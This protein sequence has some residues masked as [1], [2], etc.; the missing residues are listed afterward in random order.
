VGSIGLIETASHRTIGRLTMSLV[1][2]KSI[3]AVQFF[4]N[5]IAP[6]NSHATQIGT[7]T[8]A[9]T[10][11]TTKA[12]AARANYDAQQTAQDA[13][14]TATMAFQNS[15]EVLRLAGAAI[16]KN[17]RSKAETTGVGVYELAQIPAPAIPSPIGPLG[18]P[19]DFKV[20]LDETGALTLKWKCT[21]PIGATGATYQL[22]RQIGPTG[23]FTFL[24]GTGRK[25]FTDATVPAGTG[26]VTYQIQAVRS[27]SVGP[28]ARF[29]VSFGV[30][31]GGPMTIT[32]GTPTKL[33]A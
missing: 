10:D 18:K 4:E 26:Q 29:T 17:I 33:A 1:P 6:W 20:A 21:N 13:A 2:R 16:I 11:L 12:A 23:E 5:H 7:T 27:T 15:V 28:W 14:K 30:G 22:Y 9:I 24:G 8:A 25:D 32:E 19:S 3:D 31:G